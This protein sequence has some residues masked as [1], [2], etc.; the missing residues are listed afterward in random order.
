MRRQDGSVQ[1]R[2]RQERL[3]TRAELPTQRLARRAFDSRL[4]EVNVP[5]YIPRVLIMVG[6][7]ATR[8][9][10]D[11]LSLQ[12]PSTIHTAK[13]QLAKYI[14]PEFGTSYLSE[15]TADRLQA[16]AS[17]LP[18]GPKTRHNIVG[19]LRAV[20]QAALDWGYTS[21]P[22]PKVTLPKLAV[23]RGRRFTAEEMQTIIDAAEE[24][25]ATLY[26]LIAQTALRA[27]EASALKIENIHLDPRPFI[28]V[29][30]S[31][32][33]GK[34]GSPKT[35]RGT[36]AIGISRELADRL[37]A[38]RPGETTGLLFRTRRGTAIRGRK[39]VEEHLKPLLKQLSIHHAG[40]HAFRHGNATE[41]LR[42]GVPLRTVQER[43]GHSDP[44]TTLRLYIHAL[45]PDDE[46]AADKA[47]AFLR[48][49]VRR[50]GE[51]E[52]NLLPEKDLAG[53]GGGN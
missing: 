34:R 46:V 10:R 44:I 50:T 27:G 24:P 8:W 38:L 21:A 20:W 9:E 28:V 7:I 53:G 30:E 48:R 31:N 33:E 40:L 26:D 3:G 6:T 17:A 45:A 41:L 13:L 22:F 47:V 51:N 39:V 52:S 49:S 16:W 36:R 23:Q 35:A 4:K 11:L 25:W 1:R 37:L 32:W 12:R 42:D 43:L 19:L 18:C 15:L 5:G 2:H 29:T 14:V